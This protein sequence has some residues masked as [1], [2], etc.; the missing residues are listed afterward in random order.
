M[1]DSARV[2]YEVMRTAPYPYGVAPG[3]DAPQL[4]GLF[5]EVTVDTDDDHLYLSVSA[6]TDH[7]EV[8][9]G[10]GRFPGLRE[11]PL[12]ASVLVVPVYRGDANRTVLVPND[13]LAI[14]NL[15]YRFASGIRRAHH[16][17]FAPSGTVTSDDQ[18][19]D[20][21][22]GEVLTNGCKRGVCRSVGNGQHLLPS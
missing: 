21:G 12:T 7:G 19:F 3:T 10:N 2:W 1:D 18:W 8:Q 16:I 17:S 5:T 15:G 4:L 20:A 14:R 11:V 13:E 9:D 22:G 6:R